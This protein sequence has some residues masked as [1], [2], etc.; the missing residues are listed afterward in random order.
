MNIIGVFHINF[1]KLNILLYVILF[2]LLYY[3]WHAI[4]YMTYCIWYLTHYNIRYI[5]RRIGAVV[6]SQSRVLGVQGSS[7]GEA[8]ERMISVLWLDS[9]QWL[10][11]CERESW[12]LSPHIRM[13]LRDKVCDA[14]LSLNGKRQGWV[15]P[16]TYCIYYNM[17]SHLWILIRVFTTNKHIFW[18]IFFKVSFKL[19]LLLSTILFFWCS[20]WRIII[21]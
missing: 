17:L 12:S 13:T 6:E 1:L 18:I 15:Y 5:C 10:Q 8:A 2:D 7:L 11:R 9:S 3:V 19:I 14:T 16:P 21:D 4:L 20:K